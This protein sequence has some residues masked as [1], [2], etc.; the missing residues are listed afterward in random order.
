MLIGQ[1][2]RLDAFGR[3]R[4]V[5]E[6]TRKVAGNVAQI[7]RRKVEALG[8][9]CEQIFGGRIAAIMLQVVQVGRR[10]GCSIF[11][12]YERGEFLLTQAGA[13]PRLADDATERL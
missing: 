2:S 12:L 1:D 13:V 11:L 3:L 7:V 5:A 8:K 6:V 9:L 10:D 4:D